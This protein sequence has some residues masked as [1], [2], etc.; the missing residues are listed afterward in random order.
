[1]LEQAFARGVQSAGGTALLA[2]VQTTPAIAFLTV[3]A[4]ATAGAVI[5]ASHNPPEYNGIKLFNADGF[6]LDDAVED[7]VE[8]AIASGVF[9]RA[10]D[11]PGAG[12]IREL[13]GGMELYLNH[14]MTAAPAR[15]DGMRIVVDCANGSASVASPEA[16]RRLGA[17]V[18]PIFDSPD[19]TNINDGCG[20]L[21]VEVVAAEVLRLGA[22][23]GV[24]HDGDADRALF[25]DAQGATINGDQVLA[26]AA[27]AL[28]EAGRLPK[29]IVV[30]TVMA[31]LGFRQAM[32]AAGI[33]NIAAAVGDRYVLEEMQRTGARLGGE[34]SG[35]VIFA[36][37]ATTGDGIL[38]AIEF[39]GEAARSGRTLADLASCMRSFPQVLLNVRVKNRDRLEDATDAWDE[40]A[41]VEAELG[42]Q[43][44]VLLRP[45]GTEPLVRVMVEAETHDA[46]QAHAE[47]I[48]AVVAAAL[49]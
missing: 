22:D 49:S 48:A 36:D 34:Q 40:V 26:A 29:D 18:Y 23:G 44:R 27:L 38:T 42:D 7:E 30:S 14:L 20:A 9:A 24:A 35:H 43:G 45:S 12:E 11:A 13:D 21:H 32:E 17:E 6:K 39:F 46:A 41:K 31:N 47:R 19:G 10:N 1:M 15:L 5:S 37:Y 4:G 16:L 8:A 33:T 3:D 28:R 2:G 25:A